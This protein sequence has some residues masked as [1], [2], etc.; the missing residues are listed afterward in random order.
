MLIRLKLNGE[1]MFLLDN[2]RTS[3]IP[4]LIDMKL[5][6]YDQLMR[7]LKYL[8]KYDFFFLKNATLRNAWNYFKVVTRLLYRVSTWKKTRR[9]WLGYGGEICE[10]QRF[11]KWCNRFKA[12]ILLEC[13]VDLQCEGKW[14]KITELFIVLLFYRAGHSPS[15]YSIF[16]IPR[17]PL[18]HINK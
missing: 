6:L 8:K 10:N 13:L 9:K 17:K 14:W 18:S 5:N 12:Y 7:T 15:V 2:V 16:I 11:T 3:H 4:F 1:L